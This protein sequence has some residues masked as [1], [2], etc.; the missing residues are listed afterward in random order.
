[1]VGFGNVGC[2]ICLDVSEGT[3]IANSCRRQTLCFM[4]KLRASSIKVHM[5][6]E[7]GNWSVVGDV[8]NGGNLV[9]GVVVLWNVVGGGI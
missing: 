9:V 4:F 7:Y 3:A 1:M 5:V 2:E 8:D 6:R